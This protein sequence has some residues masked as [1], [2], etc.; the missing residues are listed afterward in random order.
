M[1]AGRSGSTPSFLFAPNRAPHWH[2]VRIPNGDVV[3]GGGRLYLP[4]E[5]ARTSAC[6]NAGKRSLCAEGR[7]EHL[8]Q[9]SGAPRVDG[10]PLDARQRS[11][12]RSATGER[13]CRTIQSIA[14]LQVVGEIPG[15][16][17]GR[18]IVRLHSAHV[19]Q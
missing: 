8:E 10:R 2:P 15:P 6:S 18:G 1:R 19:E 7:L 16:I 13:T 11:A 12:S 4:F 17:A 5:P 9:V 14:K 3:V